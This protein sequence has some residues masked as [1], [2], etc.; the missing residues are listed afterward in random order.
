MKYDIPEF[1]RNN[2][3]AGKDLTLSSGE[4]ISN[5]LM[6]AD[7]VGV[8]SYAY[9]SDTAYNEGIIEQ[10]EG[11]DILYHEATFTEAHTD[12]A[13]ETYHST[14]GQAAQIAAKA[15][16]KKLLLGHF[17]ARYKDLVPLLDEAKAIHNNT[18]LVVEG[19]AYDI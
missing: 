10:I 5:E 9:C 7:P 16:V 6:T 18:E 15:N 4:V 14:A 13:K 3:K 8:R 11:V 2:I 12:R 17:S 1:E 19:K